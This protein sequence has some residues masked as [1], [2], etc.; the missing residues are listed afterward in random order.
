MTIAQLDALVS[1]LRSR[2]RPANHTIPE[3]RGRY[4]KLAGQFG[5]RTGQ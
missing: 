5:W 4:L 3:M 2:P 1:L